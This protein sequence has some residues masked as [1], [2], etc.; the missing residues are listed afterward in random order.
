MIQFSEE[1]MKVTAP[2]T[3]S[4]IFIFRH[5]R[6]Q[7]PDQGDELLDQTDVTPEP[8]Q[9]DKSEDCVN[10]YHIACLTFGL[11]MMLFSD[12]V[13]EGDS[14]SLLKFLKVA[15]LMLHSYHRVKY[16]YVVLC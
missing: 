9:E 1:A 12:S 7:H 2:K 15:L 13:K 3:I 8:D 11:L 4:S 6:S 5:E 16:A 10:N 14:T